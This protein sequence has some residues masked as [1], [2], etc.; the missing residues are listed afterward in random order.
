MIQRAIVTAALFGVLMLA[1]QARSIPLEPVE[2]GTTPQYFVDDYIV[3]NRWALDDGPGMPE[4]VARIF[5]AATKHRGNPLIAWPRVEPANDRQPGP[6]WFSVIRDEQTGLFRMWYT[7]NQRDRNGG[8]TAAISYAESVDGLKWILPQLGLIEWRGNKDNNVVWRGLTNGGRTGAHSQ[9]LVTQIPVESRRGFSYVM[10]YLEG[11]L[12]LIGSPD[13]IHWDRSSIRKIHPL[14]SDAPNVLYDPTRKEFVLYTSAKHAYQGGGGPGIKL[15][16]GDARR[17]ARLTNPELWADWS[18]PAQVILSPDEQDF[19]RGI[20]EFLSMTVQRQAG[21]YWGLLHLLKWQTEIHPELAVSRDGLRFD[22]LPARPALIALGAEGQWDSGMIMT[23]YQWVEVGDEWWLYYN[24]WDGPYH[25]AENVRRGK[26][27]TAGTGLATV[28]KEGFVSM[29]GPPHG[30]VVCTRRLRWPGGALWINADA[31]GG[32]LKV[33]VSDEARRVIPGFDYTD[34]AT[35]S[36]NEIAHK[37]EWKS[38]STDALKGK[39]VRLEFLLKN[40]DLYTFRAAGS[41]S[42]PRNWRPAAAKLF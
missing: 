4:M 38:G 41:D 8:F 40:A 20:R 21:I 3:D 27:R 39:V 23:A 13:G 31:R 22:R 34:G 15:D 9:Q 16:K 36:G 5:H 12:N 2:I 14:G 42:G 33:R 30:G 17:I 26:W 24:G 29:R 19:G 28:R 37:V 25:P 1:G 10:L 18:V 6:T 7:D 32:E 35:F 11:G